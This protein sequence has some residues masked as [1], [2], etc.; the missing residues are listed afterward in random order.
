MIPS[1]SANVWKTSTFTVERQLG[2][3]DGRCSIADSSAQGSSSGGALTTVLGVKLLA[4]D[5]HSDRH[6]GRLGLREL[7]RG[8]GAGVPYPVEVRI[9]G[10]RI[11]SLA[12]AG[13]YASSVTRSA[14][15]DSPDFRSFYALDSKGVMFA[16]GTMNGEGTAFN[17]DG[18]SIEHKVAMVP[19]QLV[20]P[21]PIRALR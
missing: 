11:V 18:F 3:T 17:S 16:W 2:R 13:M 7:P 9:P 6:N 1:G 20:M 21:S 8:L 5:H 10:H 12:A 14:C 4:D 19:H 15:L